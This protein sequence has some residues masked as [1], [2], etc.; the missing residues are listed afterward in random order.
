M[1]RILIIY[2]TA[3]GQTRRIADALAGRFRERGHT[4]ELGDAGCGACC[5]PPPADYDA[6]VLGSRVQFGRHAREVADYVRAHRDGLFDA[7]TA[8]FSVSMSATE[9]R[10]GTDP[11]GYLRTFFD[12]VAWHPA[13]AVA[14]GG[15]LPYRRYGLILRFVMK[16]ISRAAGHTTDTSRDHDLTD[17]AA[18]A[19]FADE[20]AIELERGP[21]I[22]EAAPAAPPPERPRARA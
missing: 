13:H 16:R 22:V 9:P 20:I 17:W 14:F 8:F 10:L 4:V 15:A 21:A 12:D 2:S 7:T 19:R 6:V 18:V 11:H 3:W 5:L 1:S